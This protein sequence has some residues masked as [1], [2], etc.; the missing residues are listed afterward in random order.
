MIK[1]INMAK[2]AMINKISFMSSVVSS[3][4]TLTNFKIGIFPPSA[5]SASNIG[6]ALMIKV[7]KEHI[8]R[9]KNTA[10]VYSFTMLI[11]S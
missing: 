1:S 6:H 7:E 5:K 3:V 8:T 4:N 9:R 11:L 2:K 10:P